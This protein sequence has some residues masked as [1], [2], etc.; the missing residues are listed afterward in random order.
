V[1]SEFQALQKRLKKT[2]VIVTH[3]IGEALLLG[4]R[5]ALLEGGELKG[6][7]SP[8]EF[9]HSKEPVAALYLE[10]LHALERA[11]RSQT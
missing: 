11:E 5:I 6:V 7:Y 2:V 10:Q 9:L 1:R 3:D 4:V 8:E